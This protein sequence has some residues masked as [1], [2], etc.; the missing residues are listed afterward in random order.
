M[1]DDRHNRGR[2]AL[3]YSS[4]RIF[5]PFGGRRPAQASAGADLSSAQA[6]FNN[7]PV[8]VMSLAGGAS[9]PMIKLLQGDHGC[10][11]WLAPLGGLDA[12]TDGPATSGSEETRPL[13]WASP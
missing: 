2:L 13:A 7:A 5:T 11:T 4:S 6:P 1:P 8:T 10:W 3:S 12:T 9:Q